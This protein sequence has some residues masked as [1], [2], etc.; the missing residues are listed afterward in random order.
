MQIMGMKILNDSIGPS[1]DDIVV[2]TESFVCRTILP[3]PRQPY[4]Y[5]I[6][7]L[8]VMIWRLYKNEDHLSKT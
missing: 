5:W 4:A 7:D 8:Y 6:E 3:W 1:I 2:E